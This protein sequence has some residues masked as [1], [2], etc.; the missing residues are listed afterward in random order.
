MT[1]V[2]AQNHFGSLLDAAQRGPITITRRGRPVA[3]MLSTEDL[4]DLLASRQ[5][6]ARAVA[7]FE[8]F[9]ADADQRLSSHA[10]A[11]TDADLHA[12]VDAAR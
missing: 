8:A 3:V 7:D 6:S 5:Q 10:T 1:S 2:E 11:L 12:L 9:F 4:K